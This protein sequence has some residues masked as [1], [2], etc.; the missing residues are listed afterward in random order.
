MTLSNLHH[1]LLEYCNCVLSALCPHN[2]PHILWNYKM[3][4]FY[5][6]APTIPVAMH[7]AQ[8]KNLNLSSGLQSKSS[9]HLPFY[10]HALTHC[11][12]V[13]LVPLVCW[14]L[15]GRILPWGLSTGGSLCLEDSSPDTYCTLK[16]LF[17]GHLVNK[18]HLTTFFKKTKQ[19][20]TNQ[21]SATKT[22][23]SPFSD[24]YFSN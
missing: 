7:F 23:I 10:P 12:P 4:P 17:T 18:T 6:S 20:K 24:L 14:S 13:I 9:P 3:T 22:S 19:Q 15:V 21:K 16:S 11:A 1:F 2:N 5:S 8:S